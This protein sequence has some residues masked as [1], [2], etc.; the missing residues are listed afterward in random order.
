MKS[1]HT[2]NRKLLDIL[3]DPVSKVPLRYDADKQE[4]ISDSGRR[5][6]PIKEGI[7]I[8]IANM[9]RIV[10]EEEIKK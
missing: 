8:L 9:A 5:C 7:P 4:L 10:E 6:Y 3:V 2:I 1:Q